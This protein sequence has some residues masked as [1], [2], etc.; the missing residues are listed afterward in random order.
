MLAGTKESHLIEVHQINNR[1]H[2]AKHR[3]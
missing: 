3:F 2:Q 1:W